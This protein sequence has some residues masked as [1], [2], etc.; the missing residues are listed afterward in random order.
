[1][2]TKMLIPENVL[3]LLPSAYDCI[4]LKLSVILVEAFTSCCF[5]G[6]TTFRKAIQQF[7][8]TKFVFLL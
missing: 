8:Y 1:M 2:K 5:D 7:P 6:L 3:N 4:S